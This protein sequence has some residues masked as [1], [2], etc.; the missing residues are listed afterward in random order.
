MG[1]SEIESYA[2]VWDAIADT[3]EEA[4]NLRVRS[5][6]MDKIAEVIEEHGW[7]Q[8]EAASH[9]GV[10]QPRVND[11]LRDRISRFS[12]D[13]LV[14]IAAALGCRVHVAFEAA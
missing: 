1:K 14:N 9:C 10:T 2:S 6:L 11:L 5:E 3:A 7:T 12:L 4:A 13:A 8:V